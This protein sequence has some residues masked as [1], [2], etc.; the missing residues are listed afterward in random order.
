MTIV[1]RISVD[2]KLIY[3]MDVIEQI[4]L[5]LFYQAT[6]YFILYFLM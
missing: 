6:Y 4:Y 3:I 2:F 1:L 5:E